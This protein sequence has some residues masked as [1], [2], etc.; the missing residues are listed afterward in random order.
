MREGGRE[1]GR[2]GERE[3]GREGEN[4]QMKQSKSIMLSMCVYCTSFKVISV[5]YGACTCI[6]AHTKNI[7]MYRSVV[8]APTANVEITHGWGS[9]YS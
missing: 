3:E 9:L 7:E 8:P 6:Y 1:G 2:E 4:V 5:I